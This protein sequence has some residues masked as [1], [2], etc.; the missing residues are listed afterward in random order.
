[1]LALF[2][3]RAY[4]LFMARPDCPLCQGSGWK[5][6]ER[7]VEGA[8]P[9]AADKPGT[10]SV[11]EPKMVW[12]K[13]CDCTVGDRTERLLTKRARIPKHYRHCDFESFELDTERIEHDSKEQ[14][15]SWKRSLTKA[16][17]FGRAFCAGV[18]FSR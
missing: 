7:N 18:P 9:L 4:A 15:E 2:V 13:P 6:V 1:M 16:K 14:L 8:Q 11:G 3:G 5:V 17:L 12:A 10:S